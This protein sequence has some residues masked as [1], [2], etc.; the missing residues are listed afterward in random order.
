MKKDREFEKIVPLLL[1]WYE[2]SARELPWR[3]N[4]DPYRVWI[5]EVM[6][7]QT[8]VETVIPYYLR[9]LAKYPSIKELS[10]AKEDELIKIWEWLGYYSRVK[11]IKKAADIIESNY[12]GSFLKKKKTD[13]PAG[14]W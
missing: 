5:S 10:E 8:R 1:D 6:L 9:F 11:N 2:K 13:E 14:Y 12:Q 3:E 4:T 7:Q